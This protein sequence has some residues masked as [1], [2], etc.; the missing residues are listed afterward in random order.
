MDG[1]EITSPEKARMFCK[2]LEAA[3]LEA[4]EQKRPLAVEIVRSLTTQYDDYR[5]QIGAVP[6]V[7]VDQDFEVGYLCKEGTAHAR[8]TPEEAIACMAST[9]R[10]PLEYVDVG[11]RLAEMRALVKGDVQPPI[12]IGSRG[13]LKCGASP[14]LPPPADQTCNACRAKEQAEIT[15]AD[16]MGM[17]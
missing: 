3:L 5:V 1:I 6:R 11:K 9:K 10:S 12:G 4:L 15:L 8:R 7:H 17:R 16:I 2:S 13:C 14:M